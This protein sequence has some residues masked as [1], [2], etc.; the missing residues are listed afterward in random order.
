MPEPIG[1]LAAFGAIGEWLDRLISSRQKRTDA[2]RAAAEKLVHALSETQAY[3]HDIESGRRESRPRERELGHLWADAAAAFYGV[4][5]NIAPLL[6]LKSES[7][8]A[9]TKWPPERVKEL[10][11]GIDEVAEKARK[12]LGGA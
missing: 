11:I 6:L 4:D 12:F 1:L 5:S 7:W 9:P 3:I 10:G 8:T 2:S